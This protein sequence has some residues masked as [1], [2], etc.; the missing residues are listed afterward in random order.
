MTSLIERNTTILKRTRCGFYF[1]LLF[2]SYI[3]SPATCL[4]FLFLYA[5]SVYII[6]PYILLLY[7]HE[8]LH[9]L[10]LLSTRVQLCHGYEYGLKISLFLLLFSLM[11]LTSFA[12]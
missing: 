12:L 8:D 2:V 6:S 4:L 1:I 7:P 11:L 10:V 5:R 3:Y 9:P